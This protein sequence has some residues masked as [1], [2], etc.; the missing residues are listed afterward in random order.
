MMNM[1]YVIYNYVDDFMSIEERWKAWRSY[2][3]LGNPLR[4]LGVNEAIDKA[5]PPNTVVEFLGILFDLIRLILI[6]PEE[7]I[8]DVRNQLQ[9][10]KDKVSMN[11]NQLQRITGKLQFMSMVV[12]PGRVF[13]TR[14]YDQI[15]KM[16]DDKWYQVTDQVKK[17]LIWWDIYLDQFNGKSLMWMDHM[18]EDQYVFSTDACLQGLGGIC[19]KRYFSES[20][21]MWVKDEQTTIAQL[22]MCALMVGLKLWSHE[23][24]GHLLTVACDNQA[25]VQVISTGHAHDKILQDY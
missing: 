9:R 5:V 2:N 19:N 24:T 18:D 4:D 10:W 8:L 17:D 7:K 22:E 16:E 1:S 12:R 6:I 20:F 13:V 3:T 23:F 14:L 21:P 25:V 11:K 15:A